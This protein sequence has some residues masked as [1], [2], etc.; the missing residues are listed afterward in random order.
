M[1]IW[2]L[3]D[4]AYKADFFVKMFSTVLS[5]LIM[6]LTSVFIYASS[7]GIPGWS[8]EQLLLFQGT[9]IMIFGL[10][11]TVSYTFTWWVLDAINWG[12]FD[13]YL[14]KPYSTLLF[15]MALTVDHYG[16]TE[17]LAGLI[18]VVYSMSELGIPILSS[19]MFIYL[20]YVAAG[21]LVIVASQI[22][23]ASMGFIAVKSEALMHLH[24]K[25][26]DFARYPLNVYGFGIKFF[27]IFLF[28]MAV[29]SYVPAQ[30]LIQGFTAKVL[31]YLVPVA[32]YFWF[33]LFLWKTAMKKYTS[34]G[35]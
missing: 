12:N 35:G 18:V 9:L 11:R 14:L 15:I 28:P 31:L 10:A 2:M 24:S 30:I 29:S 3:R 19:G 33:A 27:L 32:I 21:T 8:L 26:T 1:K 6:P 22:M 17:A 5:D 34:A 25:L 20:L 4:F 16:I 23:I 13:Q 7:K